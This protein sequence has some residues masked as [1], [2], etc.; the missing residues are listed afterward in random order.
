[1]VVSAVVLSVALPTSSPTK[2]PDPP[3]PREDRE[4][5]VDRQL[6]IL[7]GES[8]IGPWPGLAASK[9]Q[10]GRVARRRAWLWWLAIVPL[11]VALVLGGRALVASG[12]EGRRA[13]LRSSYAD[14]LRM[15]LEDGHIG[16]AAELV[17]LL[18]G[19]HSSLAP[20][21]PYLDQILRAEAAAY[22]Y[23]D[24][25]PERLDRIWPYLRDSAATSTARRVAYLTVLCRE[26]RARH[27]AEL[28]RLEV[29]LPRDAEVHYLVATCWE[30]RGNVAAARKAYRRS[31]ALGPAWSSHRFDQLDFER[32]QENVRAAAEIAAGMLR[33]DPNSS[34]SR[35][36]ASL[37]AVP[38][39]PEDADADVSNSPV[40]VFRVKLVQ[41][42]QVAS[43]GEKSQAEEL[44]DAA[45]AAIQGG[46][47]FMIDAVDYLVAHK[48]PALARRITRAAEWPAD[49]PIAVAKQQQLA[50]AAAE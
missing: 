50:E 43:A 3:P 12:L 10:P 40:A 37:T 41:A 13:E 14:R 17:D 19:Q 42:L 5:G 38:V 32:Q 44:I 20:D 1:M 35:F 6:S 47:P 25:K 21:D 15:S 29:E 33:S 49:S 23:F 4:Q 31:E 28:E 16:H 45:I 30:H 46:A 9:E 26:E 2:P 11:T 22:R 7:F 8:L 18:R 36:A 48:S 27:L 24:A 34:W 39:P